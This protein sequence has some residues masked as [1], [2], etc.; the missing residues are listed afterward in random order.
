MQYLRELERLP[1]K[2]RQVL[3]LGTHRKYGPE[4]LNLLLELEV[5]SADKLA[6]LMGLSRE[7]FEGLSIPLTKAE[8]AA[9]IGRSE[10]EVVRLQE[11]AFKRLARRKLWRLLDFRKK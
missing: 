8:I 9:V 11:A 5:C 1:D 2:Y 10:E 6:S 7:Q 4:T 3:M